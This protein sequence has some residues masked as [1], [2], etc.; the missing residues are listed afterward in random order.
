MKILFVLEHYYPHI[1]GVEK[2]FQNLAEALVKE[3]HDVMVV[4]TR[5]R[6]GLPVLQRVKGVKVIRLRVKNRFG[7]TVLAIPAIARLAKRADIIHTTSYNAAVPAYIASRIR[8]KKILITFHEVWGGLW[9]DFPFLDWWQRKGY[10]A[11]ERLILRFRFDRVI[12]VSEYTARCL[13][14]SGIE[15]E[16]INCIYNGIDYR[17]FEPFRHKAPASRFQFTYFGRLGISKGL[18]FIIPAFASLTS[19]YPEIRLKLIIPRQP[20]NM[21]REINKMIKNYRLAESVEI[22]HELPPDHLFR[23][24]STSSCVLLPSYSE[25]FCFVAAECAAMGVPV[26]SSGKG[27]LREVV[28]GPHIQMRSLNELSL[29]KAMV[30]AIHGKWQERPLR[31]FPLEE[32]I[33]QYLALYKS[34]Q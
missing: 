5:H 6:K 23:E 26:I 8:K 21:L 13:R 19:Q 2:L 16:K 29:Q 10:A 14:E 32:S 30:E 15:A 27:A 7:F 25:G 17:Q 12:A 4:T 22:L 11:F 3:G 18:N 20:E 34:L 9:K 1:G 33:R 24:V 28:S 31:K